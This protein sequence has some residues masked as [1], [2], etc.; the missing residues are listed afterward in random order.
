MSGG[1]VTCQEITLKTFSRKAE[2]AGHIKELLSIGCL[3][4][5]LKN[6]IPK[7]ELFTDSQSVQSITAMY[8]LAAEA[9]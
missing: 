2:R 9:S 6:R 5:T 1:I 8:E 7:M 3:L 4:D